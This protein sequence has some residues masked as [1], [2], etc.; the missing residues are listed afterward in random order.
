MHSLGSTLCESHN[1]GRL[2]L[3][4][5]FGRIRWCPRYRAGL[6]PRLCVPVCERLSVL[7]YW[8]PKPFT[9]GLC[10]TISPE[11]EQICTNKSQYI[12]RKLNIQFFAFRQNSY[13]L[14]VLVCWGSCNKF[15]R[16]FDLNIEIHILTVLEARSPRSRCW[17]FWFLVRA[18]FLVCRSSMCSHG[19]SLVWVFRKS[20]SLVSL[21]KNTDLNRSG[22]HS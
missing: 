15:H 4:P 17:P 21:S 7:F 18:L 2:A 12:H 10:H 16:L 22:P 14:G 8:A 6:E 20:I 3:W 11:N 13:T 19:L 5:L 1:S 9:P